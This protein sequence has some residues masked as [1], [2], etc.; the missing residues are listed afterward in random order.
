M[1]KRKTLVLV[2]MVCMFFAVLAIPSTVIAAE[3]K[4]YEFTFAWNDIWGPKFRAAQV[5]RPGGEMHRMVHERSDGRIKL[6]IIS[7]MFPNMDILQAVATG[8]ADMGDVA[9]PY[10]SGTYPL[11]NWG[12][13]PGI[14]D[15]E[16]IKGFAEEQAV[17]QDPRVLDIYDRTMGKIGLKFWFVTQWEPA[18]AIWAKQKFSSVDDMQGLKMRVYGYLPTLAIKALGASPVTI[19]SG[20]LAPAIMAGT[21]DAAVTSVSFGY[22]M[23]LHKVT[24]YITL[25]PISST[26]SAV[27]VINAKKYNSLPPDL[28]KVLM[29]VGREL[30][31]MVALSTTAEYIMSEDTVKLSGVEIGKFRPDD[32]KKVIEKLKVVETEWT[33]LAGTDGQALLS[34]IKDSVARYNAFS[35]K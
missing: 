9:M 28:Q 12:E 33:K 11:W 1:K 17:F 30:Q 4:V 25:L 15:E 7:R 22:T 31:Q 18:V 19:A 24:K 6:K 10:H 2:V 23:G 27:T 14:I 8:K 34:A 32:R 26:W 5:F 35:G 16:H 20:E 13:V 3:K 21:V 29:E